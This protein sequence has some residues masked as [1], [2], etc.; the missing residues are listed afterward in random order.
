[1]RYR[2][3]GAAPA[4][5]ARTTRP[6]GR[7]PASAGFTI[8]ELL[9]VVAIIGL[10]SAIAIPSLHRAMLRGRIGRMSSDAQALYK[11]IVS[12]NIDQS[13][14]PVA[15]DLKTLEPLVSMRYLRQSSAVLG[16]LRGW[17]LSSYGTVDSAGPA[18]EFWAV[19]T[20]AALP[21][22]QIVLGDTS[23]FPEVDGQTLEGS[24]FVLDGE[25]LSLDE[26]ILKKLGR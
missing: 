11:A 23:H 25:L 21:S 20:L 13:N 24:Y 9:V 14:Y 2:A 5:P 6:S 7:L 3:S 1:M 8:V 16:M 4:C 26:D 18:N 22:V 12:Y 10:I 19:L 17:T 15:L